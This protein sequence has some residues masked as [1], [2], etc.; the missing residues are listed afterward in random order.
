MEM[1]WNLFVE[2]LAHKRNGYRRFLLADIKHYLSSITEN[3]YTVEFV[4]LQRRALR[5]CVNLTDFDF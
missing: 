3:I 4:S 5:G 2:L 1:W